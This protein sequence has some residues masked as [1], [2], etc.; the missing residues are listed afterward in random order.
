MKSNNFLSDKILVCEDDPILRSNISSILELEG[1]QVYQASNGLEAKQ[2]LKVKRIALILCDWAMPEMD[3]LELLK[4]V[5]KEQFLMHIPFIFLTAKTNL[6]DKLEALNLMADDYITK[7]FSLKE[8]V[9]KCHNNIENRKLVVKSKL[10]QTENAGYLSRDQKFFVQIKEFIETNLPNENLSLN[11]FGEQ[12][13]MSISSIQKNIKRIC[14]KSLFQLILDV[15]LAKAKE[16]IEADAAPI[17]EILFDCG[18][19]N[20]N[21]FTKKFK[22]HFGILPSRLEK[23]IRDN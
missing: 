3:G 5:K 11:D 16:M 20:H 1:F 8:L 19:N 10:S 22:D 15:R 12:F 6:E 14:G 7:P 2:L 4:F 13:P 23:S 18:F 21:H 17:S 9:L